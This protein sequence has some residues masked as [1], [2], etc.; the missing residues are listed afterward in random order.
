MNN[1]E[2]YNNF[3]LGMRM[4]LIV[5]LSVSGQNL[6]FFGYGWR[7]RIATHERRVLAL[8]TYMWSRIA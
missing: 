8:K 2:Y 6:S 4:G 3:A 7:K 1:N 5:V